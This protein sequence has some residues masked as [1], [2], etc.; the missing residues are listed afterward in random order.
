MPLPT[1]DLM[2][3]SFV[4]LATEVTLTWCENLLLAHFETHAYVHCLQRLSLV[5]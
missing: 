1:F 3:V 5:Y 4:P 2:H